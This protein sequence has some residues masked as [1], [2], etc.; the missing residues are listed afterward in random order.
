[1]SMSQKNV[2]IVR[3]VYEAYISADFDA[4][5]DL[6]DP[7]VEFDARNRPEGGLYHG[8]AGV[9]EAVRIWTG[10]WAAWRIE[11]E[12]ILDA[13]DHVVA[14]ERQSGRGKGSG[15]RVAEETA[16]VFT[17]REGKVVRIEWF[18]NRAEALEAAGLN[19]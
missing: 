15:V 4:T 12:E 9:A 13:G 6:L 8:H 11:L 17:L 19:E 18:L 1:M 14:F 2:E 7:A 3:R 10:A 5:F 16:S